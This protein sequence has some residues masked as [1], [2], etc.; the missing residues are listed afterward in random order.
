MFFINLKQNVNGFLLC[1]SWLCLLGPLPSVANSSQY[2]SA[3]LSKNY[4]PWKQIFLYTRRAFF[5][6]F[7][8]LIIGCRFLQQQALYIGRPFWVIGWKFHLLGTLPLP[9]PPPTPHRSPQPIQYVIVLPLIHILDNQDNCIIRSY[10]IMDL[11]KFCRKTFFYHFVCCSISPFLCTC[12]LVSKQTVKFLNN[13]V[14]MYVH[15]KKC[16]P[17]FYCNF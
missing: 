10:T 9:P 7:C 14:S 6:T 2:F 13:N 15:K 8:V 4:G 3:G 11:T 16:M 5:Q 12:N 1:V 17:F